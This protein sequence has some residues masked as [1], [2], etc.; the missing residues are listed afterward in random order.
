MA[1]N[2]E[3]GFNEQQV[4][5]AIIVFTFAY[6]DEELRPQIARVRGI[7]PNEVMIDELATFVFSRKGIVHDGGHLSLADHAK[8]K[9]MSNLCKPNAPIR[10]THDAMHK[11]FVHMKQG[12]GRLILE[13]TGGAPGAPRAT[14]IVGIA[15]EIP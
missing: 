6:W 15:I 8:L 7:T 3:A 12:I 5:W 2:S 1:A 4:C 14:D 11:L 9:V 13:Y 10:P